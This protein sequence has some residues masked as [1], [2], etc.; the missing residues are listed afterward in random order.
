MTI[1]KLNQEVVIKVSRFQ[2]T[3]DSYRAN[4]VMKTPKTLTA[5]RRVLV[6]HQNKTYSKTNQIKINLKALDIIL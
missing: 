1:P 2:T 3:P 4:A 5:T 6:R